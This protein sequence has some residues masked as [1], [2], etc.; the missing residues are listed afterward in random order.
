M[1]IADALQRQAQARPEQV[2]IREPDGGG[3][4]SLMFGELWDRVTRI[5]HGL[6]SH[7]IAPGTRTVLMVPPSIAFV[8]L[9]FALFAA[10]AV[11]VFV[12]PGIG[13]KNI[14]QCL[15]G[16]EPAAFVGITKAHVARVLF[17][18]AKGS[19]TSLVTVGPRLLWGGTTLKDM[20]REAASVAR[21]S[22]GATAADD[23]AAILFT[24]GSTGVPKGA[25][26]THGMF[27]AQLEALRDVFQIEPGEVDLC[28]FPLFALFGPAL[29]MTSII[30][31]MDSTKP[32]A[33]VP[34]NIVRPV[35]QFAATNLFGSPA[36]LNRVGRHASGDANAAMPS[37]KRVLSAGAPV[38]PAILERF[39][40]LMS[41]GTQIYTPYGATESLPV[42]VIG[43]AEVLGETQHLTAKGA[44]TCV[45]RPVPGLE[46]RIICI[47]DGPIATMTPDLVLP[48]GEI[49]EI[50]VYGPQVTQ[51]YFRRPDL[52]A[53]AKIADS[54]RGRMWH[55]MGDVGYFDDRGRL[56]FCGRKSQRVISPERTHFTEPV[57]GVFN[58]HPAVFRTARVG[59]KR[60]GV[61]EPV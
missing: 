57:E 60:G 50:A 39:S 10:G 26:Y 38:S 44:G 37:L 7:G 17:G 59:V 43:S 8:E 52:T 20:V 49:G 58:A 19:I 35:Q 15:A 16:A 9:T 36:L 6:P 5:A 22:T 51:E 11:P 61:V 23:V 4:R 14:K 12:D 21:V 30:P 40:K 31:V 28:T 25:V 45:G 33:V 46:V 42:A 41:P 34:S 53:L 32:A 2:A 13:L 56:W 18:W 3:Y 27:T 54:E 1:N 24:S 29:G 48:A 47:S 55:R